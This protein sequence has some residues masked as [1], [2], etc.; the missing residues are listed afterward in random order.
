MVAYSSANH[1]IA[2]AMTD[3][4]KRVSDI[5]PDVVRVTLFMTPSQWDRMSAWNISQSEKDEDTWL[6][7][8]HETDRAQ[9]YEDA[10]TSYRAGVDRAVAIYE[11]SVACSGITDH[12][13][14]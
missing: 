1:V 4:Q 6:Y 14:T 12:R 5:P 8:M 9:A 11:P 13:Q 3:A 2:W 7:M 10:L